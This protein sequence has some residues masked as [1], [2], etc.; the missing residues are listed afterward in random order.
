MVFYSIFFAATPGLGT[1]NYPY[2]AGVPV[3]IEVLTETSRTV[4]L[5][6]GATAANGN[7]TQ[8]DLAVDLTRLVWDRYI[9]GKPAVA[10]NNPITWAAEPVAYAGGLVVP[11]AT[12][13][14]ASNTSAWIPGLLHALDG[15]FSGFDTSLL[16]GGL[17]GGYLARGL[18][19]QGETLFFDFTGN[20]SALLLAPPPGST[21][22]VVTSTTGPPSADAPLTRV[23]NLLCLQDSVTACSVTATESLTC[24]DTQAFPGECERRRGVHRAA[25]PGHRCRSRGPVPVAQH[26]GVR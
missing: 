7:S 14:P 18:N 16:A 21:A 12:A 15:T 2:S 3:P 23:D 5:A 25:L 17:D 11:L 8:L 20:G 26:L 9:P 22:A 19:A 24:F 13:T 10:A 4:R 1:D 6:V